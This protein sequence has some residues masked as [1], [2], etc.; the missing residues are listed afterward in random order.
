M[1]LKVQVRQRNFSP[2]PVPAILAVTTAVSAASVPVSA[3]PFPVSAAAA[4]G[5]STVVAVLF[6]PFSC[7]IRHD[8]KLKMQYVNSNITQ[9]KIPTNQQ[10]IAGR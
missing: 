10:I 1:D 8:I 5:G 4:G 6:V 3:P 2:A 7:K 9:L